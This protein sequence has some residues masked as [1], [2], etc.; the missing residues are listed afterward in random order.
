MYIFLS[1]SGQTGKSHLVKVSLEQG[2]IDFDMQEQKS[3]GPGQ[4]YTALSMVKTYDN[5]YCIG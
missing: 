5:L 4:I 2:V 1:G 3:F